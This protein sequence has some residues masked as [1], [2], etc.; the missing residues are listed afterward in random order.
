MSERKR[1]KCHGDCLQ[2]KAQKPA[3]GEGR[4]KSGQS[5]C[6]TCAIFISENGLEPPPNNPKGDLLYCKC[7]GIRVRKKPRNRESK[8]ILQRNTN[9]NS[10]IIPQADDLLKVV[11]FL[12][13]IEENIKSKEKIAEKLKISL[14]QVD[15]YKNAAKILGFLENNTEPEFENIVLTSIGNNIL[16]GK[17][18]EKFRILENQI[19]KIPMY[20][21]LIE[22]IQRN[23]V[24]SKNKLLSMFTVKTNLSSTT[25]KR[26][27]STFLRWLNYLELIDDNN[28][29]IIWKK[30]THKKIFKKE[31]ISNQF[32]DSK[33]TNEEMNFKT[34]KE[35]FDFDKVIINGNESNEEMISK[36]EELRQQI[37]DICKKKDLEED[38][39]DYSHSEMFELLE[40]YLK[41][42]PADIKYRDV[43]NFL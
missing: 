29:Q 33:I 41:L 34:S 24:I 6:Q 14:R 17:G 42:L 23:E 8:E 12:K 10:V 26:R 37:Q 5:R 3:S 9:E 15:Y 32:Q 4:Y 19:N 30:V 18:D 2:Y 38:Y 35:E 1:G 7:C 20:N 39:L 21:S 27:F 36:V 16:N 43:R 25:A 22:T 31:R 13:L 40:D 11:N 28:N